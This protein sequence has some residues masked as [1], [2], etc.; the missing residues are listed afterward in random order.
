[1][2]LF[3]VKSK[4]WCHCCAFSRGRHIQQ[5]VCIAQQ[6]PGR[7]L[8]PQ[9][10][11]RFIQHYLLHFV[12]FSLVQITL[13][14]YLQE[15]Q[16]RMFGWPNSIKWGWL[17]SCRSNDTM[18]CEGIPDKA[19]LEWLHS[20]SRLCTREMPCLTSLCQWTWACCPSVSAETRTRPHG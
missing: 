5:P 14:P 12:F 4:N 15:R 11:I 17:T 16:G 8:W 1:M 2:Q 7:Y 9:A 19:S 18:Y 10:Q 6:C 20:L 3:I 13:K